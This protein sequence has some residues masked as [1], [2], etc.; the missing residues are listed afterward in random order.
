MSTPSTENPLPAQQIAVVSMSCRYPGDVRSP[1]DLWQLV[2][3]KVDATSSFPVNRGWR[4]DRLYNADP[5]HPGT[6]NTRRGGFLHDA[7]LFDAEFFGISHRE[8]TAMEPQQRLLLELV[9]EAFERAGIVPA[10][11]QGADVGVFIGEMPQHYGA[12]PPFHTTVSE[13][14]DVEGY[15]FTGRLPSV[16]SGRIA[17]TFGFRGPAITVDT[18]CSG[19]L[20]SVHLAVR[21]LR[22]CECT[23]AVAGGVTVMT[24]PDEL[25]DFSKLRILA[26]DGRCKSFSSAADGVGLGEGAGVVL[27]ERL[28]DARQMGHRVH[29]LILGSAI[30]QDGAS[31]SL[32]A[33][34]SEAQQH[35]IIRALNDAG[36]CAADVDVI[37]AHGTGTRRGDRIEAEALQKTY[38]DSRDPN[39]PIW[40]GSL[41]SNIGHSQAAAGV[42]GLIKMILAMQH[43]RMPANVHADS[44]APWCS[45]AIR[46][47]SQPVDWAQADR[48]WRAA[49]SSFGIS[50]TNVHLI[51][52]AGDPTSATDRAAEPSSK[53]LLPWIVSAP[54][55][56]A[57][58]AQAQRLREFVAAGNTSELPGLARSLALGRTRF[59]ERAIAVGR[60]TEEIVDG[61]TALTDGQ[62]VPGVARAT[63]TEH[64]LVAF[65]FTGQGSQR[66]GMG[67]ELRAHSVFVDAFE[68]VCAQLNPQLPHPLQEVLFGPATT[69]NAALLDETLFAQTALFAVEVS[70]YRLV[71][72]YG[73]TPDYLLGHSVGELVAAHAAGVLTVEDACTLVAARAQLM[74]SA[75]RGGAMY[76]VAASESEVLTT[77]DGDDSQVCVA[78]VNGPRETVISGDADAAS[79]LA[80]RWQ[81]AGRQ[82]AKLPVSHAFHSP[83]MRG[84]TKDLRAVAACLGFSPPKVPIVSTVTGQLATG[85]ELADPDHWAQQVRSTVRFHDGIQR[86]DEQDVSIYLELGPDGVLS[87][88]AGNCLADRPQNRLF[89][90]ALRRNQPADRTIITAL[91]QAHA[92]G[93]E[94]DFD[95]LIPPASPVVAPVYEFTRQRFWLAADSHTSNADGLGMSEVH[96]TVLGA[97]VELGDGRGW[98]FTGRLSRTDTPWLAQHIIAG[99]A[100]VPGTLFVDFALR[101]G[102]Q[103]AC[104]VVE[105]L[106]LEAPLVV[107]ETGRVRLQVFA[108]GPDDLG[109]YAIDMYSSGQSARHPAQ[110]ARHARGWLAPNPPPAEATVDFWARRP[111]NPDD[112]V[113]SDQLY[114]RLRKRGYE[115]GPAFQVVRGAWRDGATQFAEIELSDASPGNGTEFAVHPVLLDAVLHAHLGDDRAS[116]TRLDIPFAWTRVCAR[117]SDTSTVRAR[118]LPSGSNSWAVTLADPTG[119]VI[120]SAEVALREA[121]REQLTTDDHA[122][123]VSLHQVAWRPIPPTDLGELAIHVVDDNSANLTETLAAVAPGLQCLVIRAPHSDEELVDPGV[124]AHDIT[125]WGLRLVQEWLGEQRFG[126]CL[127]VVVTC[128][129]ISAVAGDTAEHLSQS[130][131]WGLL[132]SAQTEHSNRFV[133][134]DVDCWD[135]AAALLPKALASREPQLAV[136]RGAILAPRL[137]LLRNDDRR[138]RPGP[139]D[140]WRLDTTGGGQLDNVRPVANPEYLRTLTAREVRIDVRAAGVN[141][142]DVL[143]ALG[144]YPGEGSI[145][146]EAAGVV[147]EIGSDVHDVAVGDHV[148]GL[149]PHAFAQRAIADHRTV[150]QMPDHWS[151]TE[152][153]SVPVV[154][155]TAYQAIAELAQARYGESILIHAAA[156]GVGM[157]ALQVARYLGLEV[158]ATASPGKW[159]TLR[160]LGVPEDHIASSRT[161]EFEAKFR[162]VAGAR[163]ID[164]A[165]NSL[166]GE[167]IDA[168]LR[169]MG[170]SGRFVEIGKADIRRPPE[171]AERYPGIRYHTFDLTETAPD[172]IRELLAELMASLDRGELRP[173]PVQAWPARRAA[174][175]FRH[176]GMARHTGK[177]V[178]TMPAALDRGTV[179]ITGAGALARQLAR[180]LI[181]A[182]GARHLLLVSRRGPDADS[183]ASLGAELSELGAQTRIVSCDVANRE[184]LTEV[185]AAIPAATPL[186]AVIHTAGVLEDGTI[187]S[188]A[189]N[190]VQATLR[191]KVDGAL[192]L[193]ELTA[194]SDLSAF[195]FFSSISATLGTAGQANYAAANAFLDTLAHHRQASGLSATSI[196]WG[197]WSLQDGMASG[198]GSADQAR[199]A[200]AGV[201]ALSPQDG[202]ALLDAALFSGLRHVVAAHLTKVP[203][204]GR[205][206]SAPVLG[207]A[208]P[209]PQPTGLRNMTAEQLQTVLPDLVC[210]EAAITLGSVNSSAVDPNSTFKSAGFDSLTSLE[211]RNRLNVATGLALPPTVVFDHP[212]PLALATHLFEDLSEAVSASAGKPPVPRDEVVTHPADHPAAAE[213]DVFATTIGSL[214]AEELLV[215]VETELSDSENPQS[216]ASRW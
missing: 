63:A 29:G 31:E 215:L 56:D 158:F 27:L 114:A 167:F 151:F 172:R 106:T 157:A 144:T 33:P 113:K 179:L 155:L 214:S 85:Q 82:V 171:L 81:A 93:A 58:R 128:N 209:D 69:G 24:T 195:V 88:L 212:T 146:L 135:A 140:S 201:S 101:I 11:L 22:Q 96:D 13:Q 77:L 35:V 187:R 18:A 180:H 143:L 125:L 213:D 73:L 176:L 182:H 14:S 62:S 4:L 160:A 104:S 41:K 30:N 55:K 60:D 100:V 198:L 79:L 20:A 169:L 53:P 105:E 54:T 98:L 109:R 40:L 86:L 203:S 200:R 110:W 76:A 190:Q 173:L 197:P 37:E 92:H 199:W 103:M 102:G 72:H 183:A 61:L 25:I 165:L 84:V 42:G 141:F 119:T 166:T 59:K 48:P 181:T 95:T 107:P 75:P 6:V 70:L 57:L 74:Q 148:F 178:L 136:R 137:E 91:A 66:L 188:L 206:R 159:D 189:D 216:E 127:L 196:S 46:L 10:T 36:V 124:A 38:G 205:D 134:V 50:G 15:L 130:T 163:G 1:E 5:H 21:A 45:G 68:S 115:Y 49:V 94:V 207:T 138:S 83:H 132:R 118:L 71:E 177:F 32:H 2:D 90:S 153:A 99:T 186:T 147:L 174:E 122:P 194:D 133:L 112:M 184:A 121:T 44:P 12:P 120:V 89:I 108:S 210:A 51:V 175:A 9:W 67:R 23:L 123:A 142:R 192:N 39:H 7:D 111:D 43:A 152:A 164:V 87:A 185:L 16:A 162:P 126:D 97:M 52:E 170:A 47:L 78:A 117:P 17:Y 161:T 34:S 19:S 191:P 149:V 8:A 208:N 64:P 65:L 116:D 80:Q 26:P 129:A 3:R 211:L 145:G 139:L 204:L 202:L 131:L 193:H 154:F 156:G 168:T 28:A 150:A